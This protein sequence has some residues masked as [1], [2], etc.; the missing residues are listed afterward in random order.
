VRPLRP[1]LVTGALALTLGLAACGGYG[2]DDGDGSAL[3]SSSDPT[4]ATGAAG[5]AGGALVQT[6]GT[7]LGDVLTDAEGLTLYGLVE[8]AGGVPTCFDACADA[9]PPLLVDGPELP[10]GLDP[11]VFSVVARDDGTFQLVAGVWPLYR[12]AGDQAPGDTNGQGSGGV[13]FAAAPDG[14]LIGAEVAGGVEGGQSDGSDGGDASTT[15]PEPTDTPVDD[16]NDGDGGGD[17]YGGSGS[18]GYGY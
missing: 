8:D 15:V 4:E 12:F 11:A 1:T 5:G 9:W 3:A 16:G 6:G 14:S 13:W 2:D 7:E 10:A 18:G 17:P